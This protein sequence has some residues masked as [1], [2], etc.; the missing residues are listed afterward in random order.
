[1]VK[2][3]GIVSVVGLTVALAWS[4]PA[5]A[6]TSAE[7][8]YDVVVYGGTA[9]G[10]I[11]ALSAAEEG[12]DVVLLE[13]RRHIGGMVSGGLGRTDYGNMH[14]IGGRSREFFERLGKHYDEDISWFFEP[15][16]AEDAFLNWL[17]E[18]GVKVVFEQ[19]VATVDKEGNRILSIIMEDG[20]RYAARIF[21]DTSYEGDILPRAGITY[22]WGREG[23]SAYGE[24]LAGRI[25]YSDKHQ[26][27][28][29]VNP[30]DEN[31]DLLPLIYTGDPGE[32]RQGDKKV[33]AYNFRICL[34][35]RRENQAP[36]PRPEG[37]DPARYELLKRYLAKA[38]DLEMNDV[39]I[40]SPMPEEKTD[41]NNKGPISTDYI[42]GSWE[43]PEADYAGRE[44]IW[45]DH[46][47]YVQGFFYFLANDPSVPAELQNEVNEWGLAKDEFTDTGHWPHQ[48]YIREARRMVGEYVMK[49]QDLQDDRTKPDSIGMGSYNSDSHHVQRIVATE[50]PDWSESA[51]GALNEGDMQVPVQ[52]Y[53]IA[54][55]ALTPKRAECENLLVPVCASAT[56][57][58]YS[59]IRMEPQYMIMGHAAGLAAALAIEN[60]VAVQDI[61]VDALQARL[62]EQKQV[63]SLAEMVGPH[64]DVKKLPGV[65]LDNAQAVTTG[66]WRSST[67]VAPFVGFDYIHVIPEVEGEKSVR[68]VPDLPKSGQY[69][70]RI[71]Y[72]ANPNRATNVPVVIQTTEG[73]V[74]IILNERESP[75]EHKPFRSVGVYAFEAGESS[76]VELR[77]AGT[78]GYVVADA[79]QWL[80]VD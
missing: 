38:D 20:K 46:I 27:P 58:A 71:S 64:V 30:Y 3:A 29:P 18:A 50:T 23:E 31:G 13:P 17:E 39:M 8:E 66:A 43:Y 69:E 79:V 55:R 73:P 25:P 76:F 1:M 4:L 78:D 32:V 67:S 9:G 44:A 49:Q 33:Q 63:L 12:L 16:V 34:S 28:F 6:Q 22:T 24:T 14:V 53:E 2:I 47:N 7:S 36:F 11:A 75:G 35:H 77:S 45:Q 70:V 37:Y 62:R 57:V 52:P 19:R 40:V 15:H 5:M 65:V 51:V 56:H 42:G 72:T 61:D 10:A 59:S 41:V 74:E 21:M 60:N 48:L 54:Y 80:P 68:F 26:F